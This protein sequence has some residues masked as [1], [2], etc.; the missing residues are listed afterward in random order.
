VRRDADA[1][2]AAAVVVVAPAP[3][4]AGAACTPQDARAALTS[5]VAA[6]NGGSYGRLDALVAQPPLF[7]WYSSNPPGLRR[8]SAATN[9]QGLIPYFR[10]RHAQR[11]RLRLASF[12]FT[13]NAG[14]RGNF[15]FTLRRSA[16]DYRR[17]TWF[18]LTGKGATVCSDPSPYVEQTTQIVVLSLGGPGS[19][20]R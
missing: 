1:F 17:G 18:G 5:F 16:A 4:A 19:D 2:V 14:G 6:F 8:T 15:T 9:R 3:S 10:S 7:A 11:D 13:G 12:T 20:G